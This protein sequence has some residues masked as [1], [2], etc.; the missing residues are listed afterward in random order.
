MKL[1]KVEISAFR[2]FNNPKDAT[3]NFIDKSNGI[4]DFV[5]IFAPNGFGKTSF[6]DAIE[7]GITNN[8]ERFWLNRNIDDDINAL[9]EMTSQQVELIRRKGVSKRTYVEITPDQGEPIKRILNVHG[10]K[11]V[12]LNDKNI[13]DKEDFRNVILS[14]EWIA[15]VIKEENGNV[16]Y[17]SFMK[18][19]DL[20]VLNNY[21]INLISLDVVCKKRI[22]DL[23]K[24]IEENQKQLITEDGNLLDSI[25]HQIALLN[26]TYSTN[27][28][29][30]NLSTSD[31]EVLS[32]RNHVSGA[33][34]Q[35]NQEEELI[36]LLNDVTLTIIGN[37]E[38][39]GIEVFYQILQDYDNISKAIVQDESNISKFDHLEKHANELNAKL[40]LQKVIKKDFDEIDLIM[41][42]F[43]EFLIIK[44]IID[45]KA[46]YISNQQKAK[47]D[48]IPE[49]DSLK[50]DE[51]ERSNKLESTLL[52]I[53]ALKKKKD[54]IPELEDKLNS[55]T[56][57]ISALEIMVVKNKL[58]EENKIK[59][60]RSLEKEKNILK[61]Q[62]LDIDDGI[63]ANELLESKSELL[64]LVNTIEIVRDKLS[65]VKL[66]LS[67]IKQKISQQRQLNAEIVEFIKTGLDLVNKTQS[68]KCPL[69]EQSY[70]T[71]EFL[72]NKIVNNDALSST[73]QHLLEEKEKLSSIEKQYSKDLLKNTNVLK[74]IAN[75]KLEKVNGDLE[76]A[77]NELLNLQNEIK[78][79]NDLIIQLGNTLNDVNSKLE[80][81]SSLEYFHKIKKEI[82]DFDLSYIESREQLTMCQEA[83]RKKTENIQNIDPI[84][85]I[86]QKEIQL[87]K[88][89][90]RYFLV[91]DWFSNNFP[92]EPIAEGNLTS[93]HAEVKAKFEKYSLEITELK[94]EVEKIG[95]ELGE[96]VKDDLKKQLDNQKETIEI[97]AKKISTFVHFLDTKL[98]I[99]FEDQEKEI[100]LQ[101][102]NAYQKTIQSK[103]ETTKGM[104]QSFQKLEQY[105]INLIPYLQ[106]EKAKNKIQENMTD[107]KLL[108]R[109]VTSLISHE[110]E[111]IK[112]YLDNK[113]KDFF[114]E[115]LINKIYNKIDPHPEFKSVKFSA[116]FDTDSDNPKLNIFVKKG[117]NDDE[118]L[119]S[120]NLYFS[121]AQINIL[122]LSIFLASALNSKEYDC[123]FID[124]PIQS[125]DS[126]NVLSTID[127]LRGIVVNEQ[128][129]IILSTHDE[130]FHNLLKKKMPDDLFKSKFIELES[131]G[132][133]KKDIL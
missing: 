9:R 71:Y 40:E 100:L 39:V 78:E 41:H 38:I 83:I 91:Y 84:I 66:D 51:L 116:N 81:L 90:N 16:R 110:R 132:K 107:L 88:T 72:A 133:V 86:T 80:G 114:Y 121:T 111:K 52:Q 60:I 11:K 17:N 93:R 119:I 73:L 103:I 126:I 10:R 112:K 12:D 92:F 124:D 61:S 128:K 53:N 2:V 74:E 82:A 122:S 20:F 42:N 89:D 23:K 96:F 115:D 26:S 113:I 56:K 64:E 33:I 14:Q 34:I 98:G 44:G 97:F 19:H 32:F 6:Y 94:L 104:L 8:I 45:N 59:F 4:A 109:E 65:K 130:N 43:T 18:K 28:S 27:L 30:I 25:N 50:R 79:R 58:S 105:S 24:A 35:N 63:Y 48:L 127:L 55:I 67:S 31:V 54:A 36:K 7:W 87:L 117:L 106:S 3:F 5:S 108:E 21:Y 85:E 75:T 62:I 77:N 70:E 15:S 118:E 49:L 76:N 29:L 47:E 120:P 131:F 22:I 13:F 125:M 68:P 102:I 95:K 99:Q 123:I 1:K 37:D 69:C 101:S 46:T 129:Q 57:D